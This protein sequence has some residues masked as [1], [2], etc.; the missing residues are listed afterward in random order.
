M[1]LRCRVWIEQRTVRRRDKGVT[2]LF[3]WGTGNK[4]CEIVCDQRKALGEQ[5]LSQTRVMFNPLTQH[6]SLQCSGAQVPSA[7]H[8][9]EEVGVATV[10]LSDACGILMVEYL[11]SNS[12][13]NAAYAQDQV[14][15]DCLREVIL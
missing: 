2:T 14:D 6:Q 5:A 10:W 11:P 4:P 3:H 13:I 1:L 12:I 15:V 7:A 8:E 9:A